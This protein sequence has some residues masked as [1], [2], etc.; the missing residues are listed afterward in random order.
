VYSYEESKNLTKR[1]GLAMAIILALIFG[2][3]IKTV[4]S[5][6]RKARFRF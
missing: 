1:S 2:G 4:S 5:F 6:G 3:V